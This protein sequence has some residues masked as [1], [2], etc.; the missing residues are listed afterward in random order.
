MRNVSK[1]QHTEPT[2]LTLR[3]RAAQSRDAAGRFIKRTGNADAPQAQP[4]P[5]PATLG[6]VRVPATAH[7]GTYGLLVDEGGLGLHAA[8][9][10]SVMV[11]PVMPTKAGLAVFYMKGARGPMIFDLTRHF[12]PEFAGPFAPGSEVMPLIEVVQPA[13]GQFGRM[14]ADRVEKIHRVIGVYTP[15]DIAEK[16]LPRPTPLAEVVECP[17]GMGEHYVEDTAAYPLV[18]PGETV[19]YDPSRREPT[20]GALCVLQYDGGSRAVLLA[21]RRSP[22]NRGEIHW[23]ADPVN[24]PSSREVMDRQIKNGAIG[25]LHA[26][27]GP[28]REEHLREKIV[29]TVVGILVPRGS[30]LPVL[31]PSR[32]ADD[33]QSSR[34]PS[35]AADDFE[36]T[37]LLQLG[38]HLDKA[39]AHWRLTVQQNREPQERCQA[40]IKAAT[41]RGEPTR[42]THE[43]AW[44]LPGVREAADAESAA[45]DAA[46]SV[47]SAIWKLPHRTPAELAVKARATIVDVFGGGTYER[48]AALGEDEDF[49]AQGVRRLIEAC[50]TLAGV[51]WRGDQISPASPDP[52]YAAIERHLAA[53]AACVGLDDGKDKEG[54]EAAHDAAYDALEA[55]ESTQPTTVAGLLALARHMDRYLNQDAGGQNTV[56]PTAAG[57]AFV[58][59]INA[60]LKL[61]ERPYPGMDQDL[62]ADPILAAIEAHKAAYA[63][64]SATVNPQDTAWRRQNGLDTSD[65]AMA[66]VHAAYDAASEAEVKAWVA[67]TQVRPTTLSGM[68]AF[69]RYAQQHAAEHD[70]MTDA[71]SVE[72]VFGIIADGLAALLP[73]PEDDAPFSVENAA[74][75]SFEGYDIDTPLRDPL[76]WAERLSHQ[77]LGLHVADRVLRQGRDELATWIGGAAEAKDVADAMLKSMNY[78]FEEF[79]GLAKFIDAARARYL[80]AM[81]VLALRSEAQG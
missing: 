37:D 32:S 73:S 20:D 30:G 4:T 40:H 71:P 17:E 22:N 67:V 12:R 78:A 63:A 43:A 25:M 52:I 68:L 57:H 81:S 41:A 44:N 56:E 33:D 8:P 34:E 27:D 3:E 36:G 47:S 15:T 54:Y 31:P 29:G 5:P 14:R 58:A 50:C 16:H 46:V 64:Y 80:I 1:I 79:E 61:S 42:E 18:R 28:Y 2:K 72:D 77:A 38:A 70:G 13:S 76:E 11:E 6:T 59:L 45:Y 74:T 24:R 62:G 19:V 66:P 21:N 39:H 53:R 60:C 51:D 75:L 55:V 35:Q 48:D 26:S 10:A 49:P 7:P 69:L 23:F 65:E 9:G